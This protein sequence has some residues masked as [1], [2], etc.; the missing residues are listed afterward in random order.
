MQWLDEHYYNEC[1]AGDVDG[2]GL[3]DI[4]D[5]NILISYLLYKKQLIPEIYTYRLD[6]KRDMSIDI[7]DMNVVINKILGK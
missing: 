7:S 1:P 3:V 2:N 6:A 5:A 4:S